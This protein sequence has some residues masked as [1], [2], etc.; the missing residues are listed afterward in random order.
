MVF[1]VLTGVLRG[2]CGCGVPMYASPQLGGLGQN[3][4]SSFLI[5]HFFFLTSSF[6]HFDRK[7]KG[8]VLFYLK[9]CK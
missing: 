1:F 2:F 8:S 6:Y 4:K 7:G 9:I 3:K 5:G